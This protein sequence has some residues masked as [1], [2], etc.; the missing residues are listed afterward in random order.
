MQLDI[1]SLNHPTV[2][3]V[4]I[5]FDINYQAKRVEFFKFD[6]DVRQHYTV[7]STC[8]GSFFT[9]LSIYGTN[10]AQVQRYLTVKK[11]SQ[12]VTALW[13]NAIGLIA[14]S[15]LCGYAGMVVYA[16]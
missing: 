16:Y 10:Q 4:A 15:S 6:P 7:W 5:V 11:K 12:A 8:I 2:G 3:G 9:W 14:L 1:H 13:L